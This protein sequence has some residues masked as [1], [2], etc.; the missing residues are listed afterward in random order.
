MKQNLVLV[1]AVTLLVAVACKDAE[2]EAELKSFKAQAEL[3]QSNKAVAE[4]WHMDLSQNRN[5]EV[6]DEI[7]DPGIVIH[8]PDGTLMMEGIDAVKGLDK[9]WESMENM[10]I[11]H[12][13]ILADGDYVFIRWDVSYD[14]A[15]G[16]ME[17]PDSVN[18]VR[19]VFGMDLFLIREGKIKELWQNY[20][21]VG[22]MRQMGVLPTQ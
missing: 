8:N 15:A 9:V 4:R 10:D 17:D 20:D 19:N 11:I 18:R 3:E 5:W 21:Q 14:P 12:H 6:A 2:T 1:I 13:E 7:L 16:S 22:M